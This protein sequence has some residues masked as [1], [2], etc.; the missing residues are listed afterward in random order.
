MMRDCK[1]EDGIAKVAREQKGDADK[2][3]VSSLCLDVNQHTP[4]T[5]VGTGRGTAADKGILD[6]TIT[7]TSKC[8]VDD[9]FP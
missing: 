2:A 1:S 6:V 8:R 9:F 3:P 5:M 4:S 7:H